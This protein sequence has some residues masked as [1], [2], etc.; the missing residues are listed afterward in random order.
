MAQIWAKPFY[1]SK[2]WRDCRK[3]YIE[4]R[5]MLDG[6]MYEECKNRVGLIVHHKVTLVI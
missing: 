5:N 4:F 6:R 2:A 1:N 3:S